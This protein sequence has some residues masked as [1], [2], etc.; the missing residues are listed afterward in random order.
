M[1][2]GAVKYFHRARICKGLHVE[3]SAPEPRPGTPTM[4]TCCWCPMMPDSLSPKMKRNYS[5]A[6]DVFA[7]KICEAA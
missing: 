5:R 3:F 4:A 7:Q 6:R 2:A 1:S